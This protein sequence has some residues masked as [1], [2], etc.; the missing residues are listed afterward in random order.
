MTIPTRSDLDLLCTIGPNG[1]NC[2]SIN[3]YVMNNSMI[4]ATFVMVSWKSIYVIY[5]CT[6]V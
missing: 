4:S 3:N 5:F 1:A 6:C 2:Y